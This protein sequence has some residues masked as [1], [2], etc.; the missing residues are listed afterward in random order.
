MRTSIWACALMVITACAA[1]MA[2]AQATCNAPALTN[3]CIPGAGRTGTDCAFEWITAP[4]PPFNGRGIPRNALVC[5]EGDPR[6]DFDPDLTNGSCTFHV[7]MC[8]NNTDPRLP[9]CVP[10]DLAA[11]EVRRPSPWSLVL[12]DK[13]IVSALENQAASGFG[14][15]VQ[16]RN[17]LQSAGTANST[18][19][20]CSN[21]LNIVVPLKQVNGMFRTSRTMLN[22]QATS[23]AGIRDSD[24]LVLQCRPSTCGDGIIQTN[25]EECDD[26]NRLNGDGCDQG[27]HIERASPTPTKTPTPLPS[28]TATQTPLPT[29]TPTATPT[30][31][32]TGTL[33]ATDTPTITQTATITPSETPTDTA[34]PILTDTPI[35]TDTPTRTATLP[36]TSTP[37]RTPT[38]TWTGTRTNTPTKTPTATRTPTRTL[39]PTVTPTRTRPPKIALVAPFNGTFNASSSF[40]G[41]SG[42]VIDPVPTEMVTVNGNPVYVNPLTNTFSMNLPITHTSIFIPILAE[43]TDPTTGYVER[44]RVLV[45]SGNSVADGSYSP[46][47]VGLRINQSGFES[48]EGILP[49]LVNFDPTTLIH[50]GQVVVNNQCF[51]ILITNLCASASIRDLYV[52]SIGIDAD[53]HEGYITSD[54]T[55]NNLVTDIDITGDISCGLRLSASAIDIIGNFSLSPLASD[56]SS[57]DVTQIGA[58]T[59][60]FTGYSQQFTSGVCDWPIIGDLIS[61]IVG[62]LNGTLHDAL[63]GYL[64]T[65]DANNDT[66]IAAALQ[67]A[68]GAISIDAPLSDALGVYFRTPIYTIFQHEGSITIDSNGIVTQPN[69]APGAPNLTASFAVNEPFPVEGFGANTPVLGQPYGLAIAIGTSMFN[70][71]LKAE[72]EGGLLQIDL[73]S[74]PL[75]GQTVPITAGVLAVLIPEFGNLDPNLPM[76]IRLHPTTA[77]L[78]SGNDGPNG[79]IGDLWIGQ[80]I[81]DIVSGPA[82]SETLYLKMAA[83]MRAGLN[84]AFVKACSV[85]TSRSCTTNSDCPTGE[86]C[87]T[88]V[89]PSLAGLQAGNMTIVVL[90]NPIGA[91]E[92]TLQAVL[93]AAL[94]QA[95]PTLGSAF[96]AFPLPSFLGLSLQGVEV[97]RIN[98]FYTMFLRLQ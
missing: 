81:A 82:G 70:Q 83:D 15:T 51:S 11:L 84:M 63:V 68:L 20:L 7:S 47:D 96:G 50:P 73:S 58:T 95:I 52:G 22:V 54:I 55:I 28:G 88:M 97:D 2:S 14:V 59:V 78:L 93:P 5:Y 16:R 33:P 66:V 85:T 17:T 69:P 19:N 10:S 26:G 87:A 38:S 77:P 92:A 40:I 37:T 35:P 80:L 31:T 64:D 89:A 72:V 71:L 30:S 49:S 57:I 18:P 41:V 46:Q 6:C 56:P 43:L 8:I 23:S 9:S 12:T 76:S 75:G 24:S 60:N 44:D 45:I 13:A 29:A 39:S 61:A 74:I 3:A 42:I 21:P 79:E 53:T 90:Q 65:R 32:V 25:H 48:I 62:N 91:D 4:V 1:T 86:T 98:H 27:C 36:R 94:G 34:T 67:Q